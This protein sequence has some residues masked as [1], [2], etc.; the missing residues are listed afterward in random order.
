MIAKIKYN[1]KYNIFIQRYLD[2][3][4]YWLHFRSRGHFTILLFSLRR[5]FSLVRTHC[6]SPRRRYN[7]DLYLSWR[8][9]V[10]CAN[11]DETKLV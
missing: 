10:E 1:M 8:L 3:T 11:T 6:A 4:G 2:A 7:A 5:L 9:S